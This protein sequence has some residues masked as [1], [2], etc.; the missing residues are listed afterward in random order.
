[1]IVTWND[2]ST[3]ESVPS[4]TEY[5]L[6]LASMKSVLTNVISAMTKDNTATTQFSAASKRIDDKLL[7]LGAFEDISEQSKPKMSL[8]A[9]ECNSIEDIYAY[10]VTKGQLD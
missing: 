8:W 4:V 1:M 5:K 7:V 6:A 10:F 2:I 9:I 3:E